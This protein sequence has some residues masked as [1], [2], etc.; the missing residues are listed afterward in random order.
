MRE[1]IWLIGL[2]VL[3]GLRSGAAMREAGSRGDKR[4]D[5]RTGRECGGRLNCC[6]A[7]LGL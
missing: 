6:Q 5:E 7:G 1:V 4:Q 2:L 3:T